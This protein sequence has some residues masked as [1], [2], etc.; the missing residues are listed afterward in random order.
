VTG[1]DVAKAWRT[2]I[3]FSRRLEACFS[4]GESEGQYALD[5]IVAPVSVG[6][7][8]ANANLGDPS[9]LP[10]GAAAMRFTSPFN[11]SGSPS[12][13]LCG[14]FDAEGAPIGFQIVG[15]HRDEAGLL[16]I[17]AAY[18]AATDHHKARPDSV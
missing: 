10:F 17:G 5:G 11:L 15:R 13:T 14:G 12:L 4:A 6:R 2:R 16:E 9:S 3:S 7:F 18:Q 8:P 1:Q